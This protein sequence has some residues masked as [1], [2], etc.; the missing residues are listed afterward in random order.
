MTDRHPDAF[1]ARVLSLSRH[2]A[3]RGGEWWRGFRTGLLTSLATVIATVL[4]ALFVFA[5]L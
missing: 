2:G 4:G 3:T 1:E 5:R